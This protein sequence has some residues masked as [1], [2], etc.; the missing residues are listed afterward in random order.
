MICNHSDALH[1]IILFSLPVLKILRQ[2]ISLFHEEDKN[3]KKDTD[4]SF[5]PK[6][7]I[8]NKVYFF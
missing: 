1:V 6:N 2:K 7:E 8:K 5:S 4:A 3:K